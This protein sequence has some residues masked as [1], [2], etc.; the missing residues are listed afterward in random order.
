MAGKID[1]GTLIR[2]LRRERG[3]TQQ[4]LADKSGV[5]RSTISQIEM[6]G[7]MKP[8][9]EVFLQ[10]ASALGVGVEVLYRAA[11]IAPHLLGTPK[12]SPPDNDLERF[13]LKRP[14]T[15]PVYSIFAGSSKAQ[16]EP[17]N[18]I[19][20]ARNRIQ[21]RVMEAYKVTGM[22]MAPKIDDGDTIVV[23][24]ADPGV[25]GNVVLCFYETGPVIGTL[26]EDR[27]ERWV[28]N[29]GVRTPM[30]GCLKSSVVIE[31]RKIL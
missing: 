31:V 1:F 21:G 3:W 17:E 22:N 18:Y 16:K 19:Y 7:K 30:V 10:L 24:R 23:D 14:V 9:P 4:E 8:R 11:N 26:V 25:P 20:W 2:Q 12:I 27:G 29:G 13:L 6:R 28:E 15:I 5:L